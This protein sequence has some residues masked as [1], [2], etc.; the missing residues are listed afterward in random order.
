ML[1]VKKQGFLGNKKNVEKKSGV[2]KQY[3]SEHAVFSNDKLFLRGVLKSIAFH[4]KNNQNVIKKL[5]I[6]IK[7]G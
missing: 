2:C 5:L 3:F 4:G 1:A 7:F 6:Q